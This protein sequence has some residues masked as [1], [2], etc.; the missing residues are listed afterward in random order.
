VEA[1]PFHLFVVSHR[2]LSLDTQSP[3][4]RD[5]LQI[6]HLVDPSGLDEVS[7]RV[8]EGCRVGISC[9][10]QHSNGGHRDLARVE[11]AARVRHLLQASRDADV[12]ACRSPSHPVRPRQPRGSGQV[13]VSLEESATIDLGQSPE[14]FD[15]DQLTDALEFREVVLDPRVRQLRQHLAPERLQRR[16]KLTH[17]PRRECANMCSSVTEPQLHIRDAR[18]IQSS[19]PGSPPER[20]HTARAAPP[21][22]QRHRRKSATAGTAPAPQHEPPARRRIQFSQT[23]KRRNG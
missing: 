3:V 7:F 21:P 11:G 6:A 5:P 22:E 8:G 17:R 13:P 4:G 23:C 18:H 12:L 10:D 16:P 2:V 20:I 14:T 1:P 19:I 9:R 15:L